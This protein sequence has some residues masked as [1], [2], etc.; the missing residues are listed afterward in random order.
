MIKFIVTAVPVV[1]AAETVRQQS[2]L[3]NIVA[4]YTN[5]LCCVQFMKDCYVRVMHTGV[6]KNGIGL[7]AVELELAVL[8]AVEI[9]RQIFVEY[10]WRMRCGLYKRIVCVQSEDECY[11]RC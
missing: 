9:G 5:D 1:A 4:I 10:N 11:A 2:F 7:P 6:A 8:V 3:T